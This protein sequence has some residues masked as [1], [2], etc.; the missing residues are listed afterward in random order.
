MANEI[1]VTVGVTATKGYLKESFQPG[2]VGMDMA[3]AGAHRPLVSVGTA[4]YEAVPFGDV[5][6]PRIVYG[7]NTDTTNYVTIGMA[8]G[9]TSTGVTPFGKI[10]AG[11]P[12]CVPPSTNVDGLLKWKANT[13]A[14]LVDLRVLNG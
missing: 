1:K 7:R 12:F 5:S 2:A 6:S 3:A 11:D 4:A 10:R 13:A 14:V 9:T 8:T